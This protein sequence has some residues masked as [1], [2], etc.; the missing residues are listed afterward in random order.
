MNSTIGSDLSFYKASYREYFLNLK[1]IESNDMTPC[2]LL[3]LYFAEFG[4]NVED[5]PTVLLNS[6][7]IFRLVVVYNSSFSIGIMKVGIYEGF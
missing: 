4:N 1:R 6:T 5:T 3:F 7:C 2:K